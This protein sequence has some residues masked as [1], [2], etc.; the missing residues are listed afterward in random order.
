M[1]ELADCNSAVYSVYQE[2]R[3][4]ESNGEEFSSETKRCLLALFAS[5]PTAERVMTFQQSLVRR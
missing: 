4:L 1:H 5:L 2:L 3:W